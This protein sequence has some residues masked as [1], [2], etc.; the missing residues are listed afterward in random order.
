[1]QKLPFTAGLI[2]VMPLA[3]ALILVWMYLEN[4]GNPNVMVAAFI[5]HMDVEMKECYSAR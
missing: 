5:H 3:G 2:A 1:M 4:K